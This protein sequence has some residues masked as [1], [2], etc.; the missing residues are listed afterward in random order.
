MGGVARSSLQ[1]LLADWKRRADDLVVSARRSIL[2]VS[3]REI[4]ESYYRPDNAE[5]NSKK[6]GVK[7]STATDSG[8][9]TLDPTFQCVCRLLLTKHAMGIGRKLLVQ[10]HR[11]QL[12]RDADEGS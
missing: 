3:R 12:I 1:A 10:I 11:P 6:Y 7:A 2:V 9:L 4:E 5:K 8:S